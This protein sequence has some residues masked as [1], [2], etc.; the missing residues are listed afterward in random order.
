MKSVA[1]VAT[2]L[3]CA[4]TANAKIPREHSCGKGEVFS[5]CH[6]SCEKTCTSSPMMICRQVCRI[7][8]GCKKGYVRDEVSGECIPKMLCGVTHMKEAV[9]SM[10]GRNNAPF[11]RYADE[12]SIG[13]MYGRNNAPFNTYADEESVGSMY[14]RNNAPFN[15]YADEE[16]VGSMYGRN[17]APFNTYADKRKLRGGGQWK[18]KMQREWNFL[19]WGFSRSGACSRERYEAGANSRTHRNTFSSTCKKAIFKKCCQQCNS[20][21]CFRECAL[22]GD[23][24]ITNACA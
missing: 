15:T 22:D 12:E 2:L 19:S 7:G 5:S 18:R 6:S 17:N 16:P 4:F 20:G 1:I 23:S 10:Y 11:N 24:S 9:G 13:S 8:C 21:S 14:G 3:F